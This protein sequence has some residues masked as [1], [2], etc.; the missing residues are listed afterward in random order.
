VCLLL[1]ALVFAPVAAMFEPGD[2]ELD[3]HS[4]AAFV[5]HNGVLERGHLQ[6]GDTLSGVSFPYSWN[7]S[8][9]TLFYEF[10]C[11]LLVGGLLLARW[12]S[13]RRSLTVVA[14]AACTAFHVGVTE[15]G[16]HAPDNVVMLAQLGMYFFAGAVLYAYA[17]RVPV[18]AYL[19]AGC[20]AAILVGALVGRD[21][22]IAPLPLAYLALWC[23]I[24]LPL[25]RV[26][27]RNDISY[28]VYIYAF[29]VQQ[30]L[31]LALVARLGLGAFIA[32]SVACTVPLAVASWF[33]VERRAMRLKSSMPF[34]PLYRRFP[35]PRPPSEPG[36]GAESP[37]AR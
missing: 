20:L 13:A 23:G 26:G 18:R 34:R 21:V 36:G 11:Y 16:L 30:L 25:A 3:L 10:T 8:L 37:A 24:T 29:P 31:A 32:V 14:F 19:A 35:A 33:V 1:T 4:L 15:F 28:G 7:G 27:H 22:L 5:A 9:W 17:D 2:D 6:L 12:R